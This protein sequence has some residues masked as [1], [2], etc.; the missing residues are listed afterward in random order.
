MEQELIR[1]VNVAPIFTAQQ[2]DERI[3]YI[4]IGLRLL[5]ED[6]RHFEM[7]NVPVDVIEAILMLKK[8]DPPPRRQSLF[9]FLAYNEEFKD[10]I[11]PYLK[12]VVIDEFDSNTGLYTATMHLEANGLHVEVKMIP[13]HA[14]YLAMVF[15][16]PIYVSEEL[17]R[18]YY[19]DLEAELEDEDLEDFDD[20]EEF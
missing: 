2:Y 14:I 7:Y 8:G 12:K 20:E 9:T 11:D 16:R 3:Y 15:D 18:L 17:V 4:P 1:V 5:L 10:A 6:N 19:E 13:S